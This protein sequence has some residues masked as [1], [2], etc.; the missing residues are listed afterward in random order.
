MVPSMVPLSVSSLM[1]MSLI[2]FVSVVSWRSEKL[3]HHFG[4][5]DI[6]EVGKLLFQIGIPLGLDAALVRLFAVLVVDGIPDFHAVLAH[7]A[8]G[9]KTRAVEERVV[10]VADE[11]L[12][13]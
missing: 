7:E 8:K 6:V 1:R 10:L 5:L 11:E 4:G 12:R 9:G 2:Y 13:A 3:I